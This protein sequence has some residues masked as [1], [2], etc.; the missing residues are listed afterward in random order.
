MKKFFTGLAVAGIF[1]GIFA[2]YALSTLFLDQQSV[3]D[4][5]IFV[6]SFA[7]LGFLIGGIYAFDDR[8]DFKIVSMQLLEFS[9]GL[10]PQPY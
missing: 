10:E 9:S 5:L 8:S 3:N 2:V 6:A 1:A 4:L 7:C